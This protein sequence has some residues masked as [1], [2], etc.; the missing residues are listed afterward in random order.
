[1]RPWI[2]VLLALGACTYRMKRNAPGIVYELDQPIPR[3]HGEP[4]E[5][6]AV[7]DPGERWIGITPSIYGGAGYARGEQAAAVGAEVEVSF[8]GAWDF[9]GHGGADFYPWSRRAVTLGWDVAE[10]HDGRTRT[11]A[12]YLEASRH[13]LRGHGDDGRGV[14]IGGGLVVYPG[15]DDLDAGGQLSLYAGIFSVRVV[16]HARY[17]A[18]GGASAILAY[19]M[20]MPFAVAWSR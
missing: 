18:Q 15:I 8:D 19:Q 9:S 1:V 11:G 14:G 17:T 20:S 5:Y 12:A 6:Q 3:E 16:L 7:S 13:W 2:V 10:I 4:S